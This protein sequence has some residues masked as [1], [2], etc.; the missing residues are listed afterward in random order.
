MV[1][2]SPTDAGD[3]SRFSVVADPQM[4]TFIL[5]KFFR[6][7]RQIDQSAGSKSSNSLRSCFVIKLVAC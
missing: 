3:V 6:V 4:A 5:V 7:R 2:I 1:H